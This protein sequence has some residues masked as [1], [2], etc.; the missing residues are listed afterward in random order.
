[1]KY[2]SR[3]DIVAQILDA[4]SNSDKITKTRIMYKAFLSYTQLKEYTSLLVE[5]GLLEYR[6]HNQTY[7]TTQKGMQFMQAYNQMEKYMIKSIQ[8]EL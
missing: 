7:K 2:R 6:S 3:T 8:D 1:M 5:N 4:A